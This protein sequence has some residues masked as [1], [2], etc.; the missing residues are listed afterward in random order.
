MQKVLEHAKRCIQLSQHSMETYG[1]R[2]R[3]SAH[4]QVGDWVLLS[5]KSL[6]LKFDGVKKL[7]NRYSGPFEFVK[8]VGDLAYELTFP[9]SM[10]FHDFFHVSLLKLY[11]KKGEMTVKVPPPALL[12]DGGTESEIDAVVAHRSTAHDSLNFKVHWKLHDD[13][14][15]LESFE[16]SNCRQ[17][18]KDY[19][20][21][22]ELQLPT[23]RSL[24]RSVSSAAQSNLQ[25]PQRT[26]K[27]VGCLSHG[28]LHFFIVRH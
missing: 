13:Y 7:M 14:S 27:N 28:C 8:R 26:S 23:V 2:K 22:H 11:K 18:I 1:N 21:Q 20:T 9:A 19:C 17:L 10:Q 5:A 24:R 16:L 15:W 6:R 25:R 3:R 12:P 4:F